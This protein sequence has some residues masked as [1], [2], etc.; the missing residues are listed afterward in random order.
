M[1]LFN[2]ICGNG[3]RSKRAKSYNKLFTDE[4]VNLP[5][6]VGSEK[7]TIDG[8]RKNYWKVLYTEN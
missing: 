6:T 5:Y 3:N 8:K 7:K 4:N 1:V 2:K